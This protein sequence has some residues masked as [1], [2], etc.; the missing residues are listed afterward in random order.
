MLI[1]GLEI[2]SIIANERRI[3]ILNC[4]LA[5][6]RHSFDRLMNS[7]L[8]RRKNVITNY[9]CARV[10]YTLLNSQ[11]LGVHNGINFSR[12]VLTIELTMNFF[13]SLDG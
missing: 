13:R 9:K 11:D 8:S 2:I 4:S 3:I 10:R 5:F 1:Y 12:R 7:I 6:I